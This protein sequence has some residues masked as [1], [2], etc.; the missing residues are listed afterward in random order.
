M[1]TISFA[2]A[3][4]AGIISFFSPCIFPLLPAYVA[5]LTGGNIKQNRLNA[6]RKV[7]MIRS[8]GFILGFSFIFV[9]MGASA[10]FVGQLFRENRQLVEQISGILII[11]FGFQMAG[12]LNLRFLMMEKRWDTTAAK[13]QNIWGSVLLGLAFGSGWTPCVG[14]AL[15]SILLLAGSAETMYNGMVL[16][17]IYSLGLGIPFFALSFVLTY[18]LTVMKKVNRFMPVIS[19][20]SG[21]IMVG[22]GILLFTGQMQKIS[23]WL[24]QFTYTI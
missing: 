19:K 13:Q 10:S 2:F 15:S 1:E 8:L 16:L 24:A 7:V 4:A 6:E 9:V 14:L 12:M 20:S 22:M 18:S 17:W 11:I 23:A 21:W 3:F 5:H